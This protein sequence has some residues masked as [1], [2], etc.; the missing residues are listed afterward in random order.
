MTPECA[1]SHAQRGRSQNYVTKAGRMRPEIETQ[2]LQI[3]GGD[4]SQVTTA[5]RGPLSGHRMRDALPG[6][7][8]SS[9]N[10]RMAATGRGASIAGRDDRTIFGFIYRASQKQEELWRYL[11]RRQKERRSLHS[12]PSGDSIKDRVSIHE[13]P[14]SISD[15]AEPGH[16]PLSNPAHRQDPEVPR[17]KWGGGYTLSRMRTKQRLY[18]AP[19]FR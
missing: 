17:R 2:I 18:C 13:R 19:D 11:A 9:A 12:R 16:W 1:Q 7:G 4:G 8:S 5:E 10:I 14:A 3:T 6:N 15:R